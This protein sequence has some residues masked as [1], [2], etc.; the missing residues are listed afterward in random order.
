MLRIART[1][2]P[3]RDLPSTFGSWHRVSVLHS[4]WSKKGI[5]TVI[6]KVLSSDPHLEYLMVNGNIVRVHQHGAPKKTAKAVKPSVN[7]EGT[8]H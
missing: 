3:W 8:K 7:H 5:W 1:G 2:P 4:R 6:F